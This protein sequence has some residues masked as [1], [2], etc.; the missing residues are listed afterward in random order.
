MTD[1]LD[2]N[3]LNEFFTSEDFN[4]DDYYPADEERSFGNYISLMNIFTVYFRNLFKKNPNMNMFEGV[5][6]NIL[7]STNRQ[8]ELFYEHLDK[9]K[10]MEHNED[11]ISIYPIEELKLDECQELYILKINNKEYGC[12]Y[13]IPLISLLSEHDWLN[14]EWSLL[15][16]KRD[17]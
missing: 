4:P 11:E 10:H 7:D 17:E 1:E 5:N 15:P 14:I 12:R 16:I 2:T 3:K 6:Y 13:L 9:Y 8:M